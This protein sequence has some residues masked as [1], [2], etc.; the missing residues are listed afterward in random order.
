VIELVEAHA[1]DP[2]AMAA[3]IGVARELRPAGGR[4]SVVFDPL[5]QGFCA[6]GLE[7][8]YDAAVTRDDAVAWIV[9][10]DPATSSELLVVRSAVWPARARGTLSL[11]PASP[12]GCP[13]TREHE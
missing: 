4:V 13:M 8:L 2:Q 12:T 1:M 11:V 10:R 5:L 7:D 9:R 3:L 6:E